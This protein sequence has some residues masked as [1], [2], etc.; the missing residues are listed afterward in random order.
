MTPLQK[1]TV[2]QSINQLNKFSGERKQQQI[3]LMK[4]LLEKTSISKDSE[5]T[6]KVILRLVK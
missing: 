5:L 6:V 3:N 4:K 2:I 1:A